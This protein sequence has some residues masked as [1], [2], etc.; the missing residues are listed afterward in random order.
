MIEPKLT[1]ASRLTMNQADGNHEADDNE[2][3][4]CFF[5]DGAI[6]YGVQK[7]SLSYGLMFQ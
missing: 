5:I 3:V 6:S 2:R 4:Y 1:L 7:T